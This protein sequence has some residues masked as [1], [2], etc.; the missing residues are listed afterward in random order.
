MNEQISTKKTFDSDF[1]FNV[2]DKNNLRG[3]QIN[4]ITPFL[5]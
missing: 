5:I 3:K 4:Y 1:D 2:L